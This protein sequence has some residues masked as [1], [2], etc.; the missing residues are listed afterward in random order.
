MEKELYTIKDVA[1]LFDV[2]KQTISNWIKTG[3]IKE[4]VKNGRNI[5]IPRLE[6]ERL[7]KGE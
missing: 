1:T 2:S 4:V 5:R 7:K 6:V 3:L